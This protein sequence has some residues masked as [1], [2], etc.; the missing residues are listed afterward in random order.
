LLATVLSLLILATVVLLAGAWFLWRRGE[1]Q[2]PA[3]MIVLAVVAAINVA[4]WTLPDDQGA[5]P[6][7]REL[8]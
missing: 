5:A 4:I 3:L 2:R 1:R 7:G 8:R 6:I